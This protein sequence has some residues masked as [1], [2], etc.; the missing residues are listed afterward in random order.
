MVAA[1]AHSQFRSSRMS[2]LSDKEIHR[3]AVEQRMI[4]PS[5]NAKSDK[6]IAASA[7]SVTA[8]QATATT[9]AW[10]MS[11]RY[12]HNVFNTVV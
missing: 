7:P 10:R 5:S 1:I 11:S 6:P 9:C 8:C 3:L 4:E 2:I 12:S